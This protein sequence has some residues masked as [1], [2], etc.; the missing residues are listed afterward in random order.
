MA[1][2][3]FARRVVACI[4]FRWSL[5]LREA[6]NLAERS[7]STLSAQRSIDFPEE[8]PTENLRAIFPATIESPR[9]QRAR[10]DRCRS[11]VATLARPPVGAALSR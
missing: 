10:A 6:T 1:G 5:S 9:G 7:G 11:A 3:S 2:A 4:G 8:C